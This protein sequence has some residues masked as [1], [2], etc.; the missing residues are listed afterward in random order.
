[1]RVGGAYLVGTLLHGPP[2]T[3][4]GTSQP[5]MN[6]SHPVSTGRRGWA[7]IVSHHCNQKVDNLRRQKMMLVLKKEA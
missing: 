4:L 1:M 5:K 2:S 6:P 3:F 7:H